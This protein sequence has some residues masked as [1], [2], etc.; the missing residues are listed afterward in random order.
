MGL[1]NIHINA[2]SINTVITR[3]RRSLPAT[4]A[5]NFVVITNKA[6]SYNIIRITLGNRSAFRLKWNYFN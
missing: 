1:I 6:Y 2:N 4:V 3:F 5:I